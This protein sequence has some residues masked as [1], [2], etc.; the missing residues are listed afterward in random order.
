[1]TFEVNTEVNWPTVA[2]GTLTPN[3]DGKSATFTSDTPDTYTIIVTAKADN[4]ITKS[5]TVIVEP[6]EP[7]VSIKSG[8]TATVEQK[9]TIQFE[10]DVLIPK[11]QPEQT[12]TWTVEG[13][14]GTIDEQTGLF[15]AA[16]TPG[17]CV[18]K[19][20]IVN[21]K[22]DAITDRANVTVTGPEEIE[23]MV[24]VEAG[25]FTMGCDGT[26]CAAD[27]PSSP[28]F[29]ATFTKDFYI[30]KF[31]VTQARWKEVMGADSNPSEVKGDD[32]PVINITWSDIMAPDTGFLAKLNKQEADAGSGRIWRLPTEAEWE[33]AAR[34]GVKSLGY[35]HSGA[36]LATTGAGG[37]SVAWY[38]DN[39]G[40]T[41]HP[42]GQLQPNELGIYD[43]SG[44]VSEWVSDWYG[45]MYIDAEPKTD[46][47]G[48][49]SNR[50][51]RHVRRGGAFNSTYNATMVTSRGYADETA[52]S[53]QNILGFRL[54]LTIT[55]PS[56]PT[57]TVQ[58]TFFESASATVSGLWDSA[59]SGIKSLWNSITK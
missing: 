53:A 12:P 49:D 32:Y 48:P 55:E 5:A 21:V 33:Y 20:S 24:Y 10:A 29:E 54:V 44:N 9:K 7:T 34:G 23:G 56:A 22:G 59:V 28:A 45:A 11:G 38:K 36:G 58:P 30:G 27:G 46:P 43:M 6:A 31:E 39:S 25:T 35:T 51:G 3:A 2:G 40:N 8:E 16:A 4:N 42:V 50:Q 15:T 52:A 37:E 26:F 14:C 13:D 19:A 17:T 41:I 47:Q 1:V 57:P 18:V